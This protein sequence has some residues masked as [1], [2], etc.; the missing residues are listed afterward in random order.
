M[1]DTLFRY[2][3]VRR[4]HLDGPLVTERAAYLAGLAAREYA[5]GTLLKCARYCLAIAHQLHAT[6]HDRSFTTSEIDVLAGAWAAGRVEARHAATPRWPQ[7]HFRAIATEF[8]KSLSRWTPP[9]S[10]REQ[11]TPQNRHSS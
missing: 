5:P 3:A 4:R 7:E 1:F 11:P 10:K 9:P 6:P 2:P 8:L